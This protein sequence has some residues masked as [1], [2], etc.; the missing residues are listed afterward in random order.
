MVKKMILAVVIAGTLLWS[1]FVF[2][3]VNLHEGLW[4][5]TTKIEMPGMP[6][7]MPVTEHMQCL[8]RKNMLKTMM[9][10]DQNQE[11]ECK[12][13][14][15][16]IS[17]NTVTWTTKCEGKDAMEMTGKITY[18]GDTFEGTMIMISNSPNEGKI[19]IINHINGRRI[20]ECK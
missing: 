10:K 16:K 13:I 5:I 9:P 7:Q 11:K 20:S 18:R 4:K 12:T 14:N 6:M 3:E 19:K 2:A 15:T 1:T 17:G 8:T